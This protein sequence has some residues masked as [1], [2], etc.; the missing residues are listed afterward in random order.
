MNEKNKVHRP[1]SWLELLSEIMLRDPQDR[2]QLITLLREAKENEILDAETLAMI[3]STILLSEI[4]VRD[5]LIPRSQ[6]ESFSITDSFDTMLPVIQRSEFS[7]F[8]VFDEDQEKI[9]GIV[10]VKDILHVLAAKQDMQFELIQIL[11]P[12]MFVP[13]SKRLNALLRDFRISRNHMAIVLDEYGGVEGLATIEDV[14]EEIVGEIE[15]EHDVNEE[16]NPI[17]AQENGHYSV[18]ALTLVEDFEA[19]FNV[20]LPKGNFDTIGGL[21]LHHFGYLPRRGEKI[22]I[23]AFVFT[24]LDANSRAIRLVDVVQSSK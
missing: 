11:R 17:R 1:K 15:D 22:I 16:K 6:M 4:R 24:V 13:E 12:A 5:I 23:D 10:L 8:P 18:N 9:I 3:E 20:A 21:L 7:R 19:Y 2:R 14:L